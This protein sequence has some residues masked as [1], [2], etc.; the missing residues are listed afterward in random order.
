MRV[1]RAAISLEIRVRTQ[2]RA[3]MPS[4]GAEL[5]PAI[6]L[7]SESV[8]AL[9]S[10]CPT[11]SAVV[12]RGCLEA[13]L[14]A[15]IVRMSLGGRRFAITASARSPR[16]QFPG[17]D[18]LVREAE[19]SGLLSD[20]LCKRA[21]RI[22]EDGDFGAHLAAR[23][24]ASIVGAYERRPGSPDGRPVW[25]P[26]RLWVTETEALSNLR[27]MERILGV[28][29]RRASR[30]ARLSVAEQIARF[31]KLPIIPKGEWR[32]TRPEAPNPPLTGRAGSVP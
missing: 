25:R 5:D 21:R 30:V 1:C 32:T 28:V 26:V 2:A 16:R 24:D 12:C 15:A 6:P 14:H 13:T 10:R 17:L 8:R 19:S 31:S 29:T 4:G 23:W 9:E 11:T 3:T 18:W 22:K 7:L 27:A 20:D